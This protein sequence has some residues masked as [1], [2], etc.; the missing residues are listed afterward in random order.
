MYIPVSL[1]VPLLKRQTPLLDKFRTSFCVHGRT[2]PTLLLFSLYIIFCVA[3]AANAQETSFGAT[4]QFNG[5]NATL[6]LT[7]ITPRPSWADS[8]SSNGQCYCDSTFDHDAGDLLIETPAGTRTARQVCAAIGPGPGKAGNPI[9]NDLQCGH[10]PPNTAGDEHVCPGRVDQGASGCSVIGPTWNLARFFSAPTPT[11]E[12]TPAPEPAPTPEP[13]L[14]P[15]PA[16]VSEPAPEPE[17]DEQSSAIKES[18]NDQFV[19]EA[20]VL[21]SIENL[22]VIAGD[23]LSQRVTAT[24][25]D[26]SVP[27]IYIMAAPR[28]VS[29]D[30]NGDGTRTLRWQTD[31]DALGQHTITLVAADAGQP[32]LTS[33]LQFDIDVQERPVE[34]EQQLQ[35]SDVTSESAVPVL[36]DTVSDPSL[37]PRLRVE[38]VGIAPVGRQVS[39]RITAIDF[40]GLLPELEAEALP[41]GAEIVPGG[42]GSVILIW[43]PGVE[44]VGAHDM[45]IIA[46]SVSSNGGTTERYVR[47]VVVE[48]AGQNQVPYFEGLA[49]QSLTVGVPFEKVIRPVDPEGIAPALQVMG[50]PAGVTFDDLGDGTRLFRWT[51]DVRDIGVTEVTFIAID[52][53]DASLSATVQ[54][55]LEVSSQ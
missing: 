21:N 46:T 35:T 12:P 1:S 4:Q 16:P 8:Y 24:D 49:S 31:S 44:Q 23:M 38:G 45:K 33:R 48:D 54:V 2:I 5:E 32:E 34:L 6:I 42:D 52:H 3:P 10:G 30:D 26:G 28:D 9:Y 50:A 19:N 18:R 37:N 13:A 25:S 29:L 40:G 22:Q 20:P 43:T 15:E 47:L 51:P 41:D 27:S 17:V 39:L 7:R 11:P 14:A 55:E 53:D 36:V